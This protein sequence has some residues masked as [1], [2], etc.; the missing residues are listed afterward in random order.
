MVAA[1]ATF[2]AV[3]A[4]LDYSPADQFFLNLQVD[5]LRNNS[6][7]VTFHIVL[8]HEA[9]VLDSGFIQEIGGVSLLEKSITDVFLISENLV[10]GAGMPLSFACSGENAITLQT[11][12]NLI[13]AEAFQV[14]SINALYNFRLF[15]V[16]DKVAVRILCVTE[17]AVVV[18]LH[19]ALLIAELDAHLHV[20]AQGL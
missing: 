16:D 17:E 2:L 3:G 12:C 7:V 4:G 18:D 8:R 9:V 11:G 14:F 20:L 5:F 6:F 13:H 19:F 15:R 1:V 10:D